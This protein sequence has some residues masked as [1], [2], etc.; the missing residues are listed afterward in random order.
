MPAR[1]VHDAS[2]CSAVV[3]A[4]TTTAQPAAAAATTNTGEAE[5]YAG[6]FWQGVSKG[7][8]VCETPV[9]KCHGATTA[10]T[11]GVYRRSEQPDKDCDPQRAGILRGSGEKQELQVCERSLLQVVQSGQPALRTVATTAIASATRECSQRYD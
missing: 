4:A 1:V 2:G 6:F 10:A 11:K 9:H 5:V 3:A 8:D 7:A